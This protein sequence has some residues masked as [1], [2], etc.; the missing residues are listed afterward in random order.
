MELK[1]LKDRLVVLRSPK[2]KNSFGLI[3]PDS[4]TEINDKGRVLHVGP[5]VEGVERGHKILFAKFAGQEVKVDGVPMVIL[6]MK[7]VIAILVE[8]EDEEV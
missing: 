3:I 4:P 8:T 5:D 1:P 6:T 2:P 7:D